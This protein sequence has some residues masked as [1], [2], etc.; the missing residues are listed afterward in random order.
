MSSRAPG[1]SPAGM[2]PFRQDDERRRDEAR[3]STLQ[4]QLD[5][6]RQALRELASRQVRVEE[7]IKQYEGGSAQNRL[8]LEQ[9]RQETQQSAQ[10]RALDENRTRQQIG[11]LEQRIDDA[12]RPIRSLTAHV[13]ELLEASR[14]KVDD[15]GQHLR[16][17]DELRGMIEHVQALGD[18]N[19]V[20][21]HQL[22]DSIDNV[23]S[24]S[25]QIR[26][27]MLRNEDAI[28]I[29]DQEARRRVAEVVQAGAD[30][31]SRIDELRSDVAHT[32]DLIEEVRR[33]ITHVDPTLEE[34]RQ[35]DIALR[36]DIVR[37][38]Q[39]AIER[40]ETLV[41][42][43]EDTRQ[44]VDAQF[45][46]LRTAIEQRYERLGERI[47]AVAEQYRELGYRLSTFVLQL[48]ELKQVDGTLR[49][50]LWALHEQRVRLRLEQIQQELELV[51]G[52]RRIA[53]AAP[54]SDQKAG[55][56]R[57]LDT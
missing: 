16:R 2:P 55:T 40:H 17:Y 50:D 37:F 29:V 24:E 45:D 28:K 32:F 41:E 36:Q 35:I 4:S 8:G 15:S 26:R 31:S 21:T 30:V 44:A 11:D 46:E 33:S 1:A 54:A 48:D 20:M 25:E 13:N 42:R 52:S 9:L 34:L 10:A 56:I 49:R 53:E 51:T 43:Q 14:K 5:E 27:D 12:T 47:E 57:S 18:R 7:T 23:R 6:L 3:L 39:Q 38:Q 19:A 22:R